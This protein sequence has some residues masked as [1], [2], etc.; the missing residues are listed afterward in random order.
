MPKQR[1]LKNT[2]R[3]TGVG[4]HSG[5]KVFLTLR[6]APIDTGIVFRRVDLD[7]VVEIPAHG[8][9]VTETMLCTGLTRG[10]GKVMTVEHLMSALAGL[11]VEFMEQPLAKDDL[12]GMK[13]VYQH[14]HL[15]VI[16][17]ESCITEAD[18]EKCKGL[19]HGINV[20]LMKAG[21]I[22]PALR[23]LAEARSYGMKTM[24]GCMTESSVGISAIAHIAPLLDYV[25]MDGAM[26]LAKDIAQ[27]VIIERDKVIFPEGDGIGASLL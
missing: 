18:V 19:F 15:P 16:A 4:L 12:D 1:T 25:D 2:I 24:V 7:P 5:E 3:A 21:G 8:E 9:L 27:G 14:S 6:P 23:M 13:A 17:D 10:A 26:L 11:G 20:K 22:T